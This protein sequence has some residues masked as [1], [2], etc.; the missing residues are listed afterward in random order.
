MKLMVRFAISIRADNRVVSEKRET[1]RGE[2]Y[3]YV[4]SAV[5]GMRFGVFISLREKRIDWLRLQWLD[6]PIKG[7]DD[8]SEEALR[9]EYR[10]LINFVKNSVGRRPN[11]KSSGNRTWRFKWPSSTTCP[12]Q[13]VQTKTPAFTLAFSFPLPPHLH[14]AHKVAYSQY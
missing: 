12:E 1:G 10:L 5:D 6:S 8:V 13:A 14:P 7:W 3:Y 9:D 4:E 11:N 2:T